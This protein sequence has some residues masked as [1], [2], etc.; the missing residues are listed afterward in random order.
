MHDYKYVTVNYKAT[1]EYHMCPPNTFISCPITAFMVRII[2]AFTVC[3]SLLGFIWFYWVP[4]YAS[5]APVFKMNGNIHNI[6]HIYTSSLRFI[7][8]VSFSISLRFKYDGLYSWSS[9]ILLLYSFIQIFI[10]KWG[11]I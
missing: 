1:P 9:L 5:L 10:H 3:I 11:T 2:T 4:E 8:Y 7:F 6:I